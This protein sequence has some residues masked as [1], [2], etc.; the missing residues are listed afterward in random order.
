MTQE[1]WLP[2]FQG[3]GSQGGSVSVEGSPWLPDDAL[4]SHAQ[5]SGRGV[6][7]YERGRLTHGLCRDD[8]SSCLC[9]SAG[10]Q[11]PDL[12]QGAPDSSEH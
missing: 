12:S 4:L 11:V 6:P 8:V 1:V 9:E 5:S 7:T 2:T 3:G 10:T